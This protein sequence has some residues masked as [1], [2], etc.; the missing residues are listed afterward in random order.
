MFTSPLPDVEIPNISL[1]DYLFGDIKDDELARVAFIDGTTGAE[2]SYAQLIGQINS[3]AGA[4]AAR[5]TE[6]GD[7]VG[8]LCPNVP[9]FSTVFHGILRAGATATT[10][11][12]L[13][14]PA[15]IAAQQIG[16]AHV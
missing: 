14:T 12:S 15:E 1:F 9:A 8:L 6:V 4:L 7:V 13:Y 2:V 11:N 10:I 3:F 16:R 5:G